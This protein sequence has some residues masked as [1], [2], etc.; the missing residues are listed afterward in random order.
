MKMEILACGDGEKTVKFHR[1]D[2]S[3]ARKN[4]GPSAFCSLTHSAQLK[5]FNYLIYTFDEVL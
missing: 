3:R 1:G 5:R 2:Y 4:T